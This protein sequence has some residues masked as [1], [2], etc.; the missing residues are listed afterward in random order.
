M[1]RWHFYDAATG[2][3]TGNS[4]SYGGV[5]DDF[6]PEIP[7]G[8]GAY[9]GDADHRRQKV[10]LATGELVP[11]VPA[12]DPLEPARQAMARIAA[13][14]GRQH[15]ALR[16]HAL[17]VAGAIGRVAAIDAEIAALRVLLTG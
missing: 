13:L 11:H 12:P 6:A 14:E 9:V 5:P 10:D 3:L 1:K 15:R 4:V 7:D 2:V 17:G 16:E 8:H